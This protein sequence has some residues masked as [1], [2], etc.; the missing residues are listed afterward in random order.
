M[1]ELPKLE[2]GSHFWWRVLNSGPIDILGGIIPYL[3][4]P[5]LCLVEWYQHP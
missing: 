1:E 2:V 3:W 4:G 5:V